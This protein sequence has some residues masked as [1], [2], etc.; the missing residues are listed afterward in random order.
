M[1]SFRYITSLPRSLLIRKQWHHFSGFWGVGGEA[2]HHLRESG[3]WSE[4]G[5]T[6]RGSHELDRKA[7]YN[8]I[9]I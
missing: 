6:V 3:G 9:I 5:P 8:V 4:D 2:S 7:H 1:S